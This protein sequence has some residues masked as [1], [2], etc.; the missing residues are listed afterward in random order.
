[1][2]SGDGSAFPRPLSKTRNTLT[3]VYKSVSAQKRWTRFAGAARCDDL[4]RRTVRNRPGVRA[5]CSACSRIRS[6]KSRACAR[7]IP[8]R[9][10]SGH[11][12]V[13]DA[14]RSA[15]AGGRWIDYLSTSRDE[16]RRGAPVKQRPRPRAARRSHADES[17]RM[18][19]R[20]SWRRPCTRSRRC[21]RSTAA[22]R[23]SSP[24]RSGAPAAPLH[25][26]RQNRRQKPA[27]HSNGRAIASTCWPTMAAFRDLQRHRLLTLEW[28]PLSTHH[29]CVDRR[30]RGGGCACRLARR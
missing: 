24:R 12:R 5:C 25:R 2:D 3:G 17:I 11:S 7:H 6:R 20:R 15:G 23:V 8:R 13:R 4:E 10:A 27:A 30:H 18:A 14:R 28:Q 9:T 29:G 19:K 16:F 21:R 1:M 26:R 22:R